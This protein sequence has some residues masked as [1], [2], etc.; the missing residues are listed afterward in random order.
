MVSNRWPAEHCQYTLIH[1]KG[2]EGYEPSGIT[3]DGVQTIL[4][5]RYERLPPFEG[6]VLPKKYRDKYTDN[7]T[8]QG[9]KIHSPTVLPIMPGRGMGVGDSPSLKII[10]DVDPSDIHQ[11]AVSSF[12]FEIVEAGKISFLLVLCFQ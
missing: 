3:P 4:M 12:H 8:H 2:T 10:G 6:N 7:M 1:R 5:Y 9:R 11:G